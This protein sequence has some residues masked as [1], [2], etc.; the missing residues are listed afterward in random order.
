MGLGDGIRELVADVGVQTEDINSAAVTASKIAD[1]AVT[2]DK[3]TQAVGKWSGVAF[4]AGGTTAVVTW[5]GTAAC[6]VL[7]TIV[8]IT[9][10]CTANETL[11]VQNTAK[12]SIIL[13]AVSGTAIKTIR[14]TVATALGDNS[15]V[16][17]LAA[18]E[19]LEVT[20]SANSD[21]CAGKLFVEYVATPS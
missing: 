12:S 20:A 19:S 17:V 14:N 16:V 13:A 1:G 9:T 8:Q 15:P 21:E 2:D 4:V 3:L 11:T 18:G 7:N 10:A 6:T 5:T